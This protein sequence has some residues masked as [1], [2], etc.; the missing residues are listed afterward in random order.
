LKA[1]FSR[2]GI[3]DELFTDNGPQYSSLE[4]KEYFNEWGFV[5]KTSSSGFSK[6]NGLIDR[7]VQTAKRIL[8]NRILKLILM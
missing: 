4:F 8:D 5:H 2:F 6:S 3:P 1:H 7:A